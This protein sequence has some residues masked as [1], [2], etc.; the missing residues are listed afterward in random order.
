MLFKQN[1]KRQFAA[2]GF[3]LMQ[4]KTIFDNCLLK[5]F[6]LF[7][8]ENKLFPTNRSKPQINILKKKTRES[9]DS[10]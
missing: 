1:N 8:T 9:Q 5:I 10:L 6:I 2:F 4:A 3:D 7:L